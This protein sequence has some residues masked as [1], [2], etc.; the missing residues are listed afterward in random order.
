MRMARL[1]DLRIRQRRREWAERALGVLLPGAAG[2][3]ARRPLLGLLGALA[4]GGLAA[5]LGVGTRLAPDPLAVGPTG[6]WALDAAIVLLL[7]LHG[8]T[9]L[10][11]WTLREEA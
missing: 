7:L 4:A 10:L 11:A 1:T 2:T 5:V 8:V 6:R 3:L 9:T